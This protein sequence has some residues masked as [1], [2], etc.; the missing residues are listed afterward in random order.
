V[1]DPMSPANDGRSSRSLTSVFTRLGSLPGPDQETTLTALGQT[2][3][4]KPTACRYSVERPRL[5]PA[6]PLWKNPMRYST[7]RRWHLTALACLAFAAGPA[8]STNVQFVGATAYNCAGG[9]GVLSADQVA[10]FDPYYSGTLHMELWAFPTPYSGNFSLGYKLAQHSLGQLIA[11]FAFYSV[12]SGTVFCIS[13]PNGTWYVSMVLTEYTGDFLNS[14][15]VPRDYINFSNVMVVGPP[16]PPPP[17]GVKTA[18]VEYFHAGFD[19]YFLTANPDEIFKLD[20]GVFAGWVRTGQSF[21]VYGDAPPGTASV[22]RFFS[23]AFAP[24]SS[25][26]YTPDPRECA[27]VQRNAS[28]QYEAVVFHAPMPDV[29]GTCPGGTTPVYR[30]YNNGQGAAP[31]HRYTTNINVRSQM[32][33]RGWIPEGYGSVGVIMCA[34]Q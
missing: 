6:L 2:A 7:F 5:P 8:K 23:T 14:G 21:N 33:A 16:P 22:C 19:H 4:S 13:P 32:L 18:A 12:N 24:K 15:Y 1:L 27:T 10:N 28:W 17:P 29:A 3:S 26:F 11:G 31:N 20:S 9:F 30:L 25:H 34:P